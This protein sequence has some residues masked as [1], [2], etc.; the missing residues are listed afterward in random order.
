MRR[1]WSLAADTP[2]GSQFTAATPALTSVLP[3]TDSEERRGRRGAGRVQKT[4]ED[5]GGDPRG[6]TVEDQKEGGGGE[7]SMEMVGKFCFFHLELARTCHHHHTQIQTQAT[8]EN[9]E[10][11]NF[12][13]LSLLGGRRRSMRTA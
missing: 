1:C 7:E 4:K 13:P 5:E 11:S 3:I 10:W 12:H 8:L 2:M 6:A 9:A